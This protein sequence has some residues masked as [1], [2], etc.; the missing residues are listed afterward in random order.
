MSD[1]FS[2]SK[3]EH[4]VPESRSIGE[5]EEVAGILEGSLGSVQAT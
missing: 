1:E 2:T 5:I 4:E 3:Q